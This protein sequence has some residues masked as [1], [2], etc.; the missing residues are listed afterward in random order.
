MPTSVEILATGDLGP[1]RSDPDSIFSQVAQRLHRADVVLG[2]L[3]PVLTTRGTR[4]PQARLAMRSAPSTARAIRA[5]GFDVVSFASNHCMDW[6]AEGLLD[7]VRALQASDLLVIGAGAN[8]QAAR[9]PV[10]IRHSHGHVAFLAYNSI[11]PMGYW[12]ESN[13]AGCAPLRAFTHYEQ[14]EHD[15]PGTP[16]RV[17]SHPHAEDVA[18]MAADIATARRNAEV[19]I[20]SVHWGIHFVPATIAEYQRD[21]ARAAIDAGADAVIGHHPHVLKGVEVYKGK[22]IFYSLGNFAIDPPTSFQSNLTASRAHREIA[23]LNPTWKGDDTKLILPES[24]KALVAKLIVERGA[25]TSV[26]ALP[27]HIDDDS[28][29]VFLSRDDARFHEL[30]DYM[31]SITQSQGLKGELA[32]SGNEL[33]IG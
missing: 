19:V 14:I 27:V 33:L 12:A 5:A 18:N 16:C 10:A 28:Q 22:V 32:I 20:V 29:P 25:V 2:Q 30:A 23:A 6:G 1:C 4:A 24:C 31:A 13:R 26:S 7:T 11:L 15:Q 3:E 17:R 9:R 21:L 8:I